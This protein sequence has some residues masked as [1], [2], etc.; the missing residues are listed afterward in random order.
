MVTSISSGALTAV[1]GLLGVLVGTLIGPYIN[2]KLNLK[3]TRK[4]IIFKRKLEYFEKLAE[5][6]EKN[7]RT[8]RNTIAEA[9]FSVGKQKLKKIYKK[10]KQNRKNFLIM[11]S[12][13]YFNIRSLSE[14]IISFVDIEKRMFRDFEKLTKTSN[15]QH[16]EEIILNLKE[17]LKNLIDFGNKVVWE[18]KRE[19]HK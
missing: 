3:N 12:P 17:K 13:L 9:E 5:S 19:L 18:M 11:A 4:D 8:Y 1:V 10:L 16:K 6:I 15:K 2:H 7:I 14:K